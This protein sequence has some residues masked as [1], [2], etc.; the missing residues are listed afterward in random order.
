MNGEHAKASIDDTSTFNGT[1]TGTVKKLTITE[2]KNTN[3]NNDG[4]TALLYL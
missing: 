2:I 4:N 3:T 1:Q